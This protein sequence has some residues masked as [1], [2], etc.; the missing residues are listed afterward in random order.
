MF[1]LSTVTY[2]SVHIN[3]Y[4]NK[5]SDDDNDDDVEKDEEDE[6]EEEHLAPADPSTVPIDDPEM[7]TTVN[8]GM[9]V[10][11]IERVVAQ[12]LANA[13]EAIA[14]YETKT[15]IARKSVIPTERQEDNVAENAS[16]KRKW[17]DNHNGSSSQQNKGHKVPRAHIT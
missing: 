13:I 6:E 4:D 12:R 3:N 7:M 2:T 8:Q 14:I 11:E 1:S 10:E 17:E 5:S 9:S 15:N 16:N